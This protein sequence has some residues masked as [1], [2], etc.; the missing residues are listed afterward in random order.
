MRINDR[1]RTARIETEQQWR[2][3]TLKCQSPHSHVI[4]DAWLEQSW[5]MSAVSVHFNQTCAPM[6]DPESVRQKFIASQLYLVAKPILDELL[7]AIQDTGFAIGLSDAN[8]TLQWTASSRVMQKRL[9]KAHFVPSAHWDE[10]SIGTNAVGLA[11]RLIKPAA[12]FSAQ[13]YVPS[14][15]E[16]V[17]YAAPIVHAPTGQLAG[18]LD[19]SAPWQHSTPMALATVSHYAQQISQLWSNVQLEPCF[20]LNVCGASVGLCLGQTVLPRRLQEIFIALSLHP[21][22]LSL[23]AL[24]AQVYGDAPVSMSTLKSEITHL[25][26]HIGERLHARPYRLQLSAQIL[27]SDAHLI[28]QYALQGMVQEAMTLYQRPLLAQ[29]Q[30]PAVVEFRDYLH[31]LVIGALLKSTD[32]EALWQFTLKHETEYAILTRLDE[33]LPSSDGRRAAVLSKLM[34]FDAI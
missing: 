5:Q 2:A 4:Q 29:S 30:A 22:G 6:D 25:R 17:C 10:H 12:I 28:E 15:H 8:A 23:E 27:A 11:A 31:Q 16:W 7:H 9:E 3:F 20:Y 34:Q 21:E 19:I 14:L 18:V 13:H 32:I 1:L 33:L 26:G 24:H